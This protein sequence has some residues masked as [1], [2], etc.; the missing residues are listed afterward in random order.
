MVAGLSDADRQRLERERERVERKLARDRD[1]IHAQL[2]AER[3]RLAD[4]EARSREEAEMEAAHLKAYGPTTVTGPDGV[5]AQLGVT[6][7]GRARFRRPPPNRGSDGAEALGCLLEFGPIGWAIAAVIGLVAGL[8][9][10]AERY[11]NKSG[12][13]VW[14]QADGLESSYARRRVA[15]EDT[16]AA[17]FA[18]AA[19]AIRDGGLAGLRARIQP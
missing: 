3:R 19:Q 7:T 1:A 4:K 5:T 18:A 2:A 15:D 13:V 11:L 14:I 6:S 16:A 8:G 17:L 12:F 9:I 10:L